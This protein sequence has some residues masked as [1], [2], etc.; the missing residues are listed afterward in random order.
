[1]HQ[2]EPESLGF[3]DLVSKCCTRARGLS[4]GGGVQHDLFPVGA[5]HL[6]MSLGSHGDDREVYRAQ[7]LL[8]HG[9]KEQVANFAPAPGPKKNAIDI[10]LSHSICDLT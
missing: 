9:T 5:S 10:E 3:C 1:M 4:E 7:H 6:E 8:R 2:D